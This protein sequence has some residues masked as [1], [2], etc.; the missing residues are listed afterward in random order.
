MARS[1]GYIVKVGVAVY[2]AV[3]LAD[4]PGQVTIEWQGPGLQT[5][6]QWLSANKDQI[7]ME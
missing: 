6:A 1:I 3:W 4:R 2:I 7:P 5:F